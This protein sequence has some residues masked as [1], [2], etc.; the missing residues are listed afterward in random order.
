MEYIDGDTLS[1]VWLDLSE[2][3]QKD[4]GNRVVEIMHT[5][6]TKTSFKSIGGIS[7]DGT[8]CPLVDGADAMSGRAVADSFGLYNIGPYESV[9]EYIQSVF[10]RQFHYMDQI[11]HKGILSTREAVFREEA[12]LYLR[13]LTLEEAFE[14]V[15]SKRDDFMAQ[16]YD[17]EYPFVLRHGDLHGRNVIVSRTSPRRILAILDWDFGGSHALPFA[18]EGFEVSSPDRSENTDVR[19]QQAE[20]IYRAQLHL[21]ELA[22]TLPYDTRLFRLVASTWLDVLDREASRARG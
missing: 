14:R 8:S 11:L 10:D 21:D 7:P 2:E 15:K 9:R 3:E 16:P 1:D 5:M 13:S 12:S 18:D 19:I 17:C 20:E 4:V 22:G 6:R